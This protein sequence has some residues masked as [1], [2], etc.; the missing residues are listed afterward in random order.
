[1]SASTIALTIGDP[2]GIGPE[3]AVKAAAQMARDGGPSIILVGDEFVIRS[4]AER[5]AGD[6]ALTPLST[7]APRTGAL[8]FSGVDALPREAF[9]P[10]APVAAGGRAT[11]DYVAAAIGLVKQGQA[12]AIV[13]CPHSETNVNAAG[14]PFSGYPGLLARLSGIPE[15]HVFLMLVGGGLRIVHVTLHE[16]LHTALA[17]ITPELVERAARTAATA[18]RQLNVEQPRIGL[19]GINP[20]AGENGLFGDDDD[21][22][23]VPA[24]KSLRAAGLNVEGPLGAD[25]MLGRRDF[26][27]FVAMYHDQ[28]H[29]P[30]K[31]IAGR[32]SAAMSIGAGVLFASVGH[33]SA[34]DIAGK[35]V[36]EPDAVLRSIKLLSGATDLSDAAAS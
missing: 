10:G 4:Y 13:A 9:N 24:A 17:R 26:D 23:T 8:Y 3:I 29:I 35:G 31:L 20:H 11:V 19:F 7:S 1:M 28:G 12:S 27:A 25:L 16:R 5:H 18:L 36:A 34:F 33:G 15:D 30:V 14:I 32:N 6:L 2:N 22:I 21:H